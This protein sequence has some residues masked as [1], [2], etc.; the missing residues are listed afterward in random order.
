M[1]YIRKTVTSLV[2]LSLLALIGVGVFFAMFYRMHKQSGRT[3]EALAEIADQV[4][5]EQEFSSLEKTINATEESRQM[6]ASHFISSDRIVDFLETLEGY[7]RSAGSEF[8]LLSV[9]EEKDGK[10]LRVSF[11]AVGTFASVYALAV[12]LENTPYHIVF[13]HMAVSR[14]D[15]APAVKGAPVRDWRLTATI[16][17]QSFIH[18]RS[19]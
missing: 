17:L 16:R 4:K 11:E 5:K 14:Y 3:T 19:K 2:I 1:N 15:N 6:L 12:L 9:E 13:D 8:K 18:E 10:S 7:G